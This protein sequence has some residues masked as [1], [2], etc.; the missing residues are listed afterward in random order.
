MWNNHKTYRVCMI[1]YHCAESHAEIRIHI[2]NVI[3]P[4]VDSATLGNL[5]SPMGEQLPV[6]SKE[7]YRGIL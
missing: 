4:E 6:Q 5:G 3:V 2:W 7:S 1:Y